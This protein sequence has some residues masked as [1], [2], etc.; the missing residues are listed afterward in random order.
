MHYQTV[1]ALSRL[2]YG[3]M[4]LMAVAFGLSVVVEVVGVDL[5]RQPPIEVAYA[6][7]L[8]LR[9]AA[10]F[11]A[12]CAFAISFNSAAP[13]VLAAGFVALGANSLR[14]VLTDAGMMLAPAAFFGSLAIGLLALLAHPRFD[15]P[16]MATTVAP[17]VIMIPGL[18]AFQMIVLFNRG[19]VL[20][21]LQAAALFG[22][23]VGALAM[24][25][26]TARFFSR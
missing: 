20:E 17:T 12:S 13:A 15:L 23:V 9:A 19:Q 18:Y 10:S 2:A 16:R 6:V 4:I 1:A 14:L 3:M 24:G 26:V 21:A 5:S 7:K 22:F 25:L 8:L 11:I